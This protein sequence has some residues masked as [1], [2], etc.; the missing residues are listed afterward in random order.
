MSGTCNQQSSL[1]SNNSTLIHGVFYGR[2]RWLES[3]V[4]L[5]KQQ[6]HF[7]SRQLKLFRTKPVHRKSALQLTPDFCLLCGLLF[8][9]A[10]IVLCVMIHLSN[11]RIHF[12]HHSMNPQC[13][14]QLF[15]HASK[16]NLT[17][18]LVNTL[19]LICFVVSRKSTKMHMRYKRILN[20][21]HNCA[22]RD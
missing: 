2:T 10:S 20:S 21:F 14:D 18:W 12:K 1:A 4:L 6:Q 11:I 16:T 5:L 13:I 19:S 22:H 7:E 8:R 15:S 17:L 3:F 9:V